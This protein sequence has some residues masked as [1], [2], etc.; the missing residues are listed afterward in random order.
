MNIES[1]FSQVAQSL[2]HKALLEASGTPSNVSRV[3]G[4]REAV[5]EQ[6]A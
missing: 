6:V 2:L 4:R 1:G 5:A 3:A